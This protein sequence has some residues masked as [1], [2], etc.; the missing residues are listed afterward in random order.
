MSD[1]GFRTL[2]TETAYSGRS[3]VRL[4]RVLTPAGEEV[5]R[6]IVGHDDAVAVVPV[7]A[8]G[9]VVLLRQYRQAVRD[10]VLE[11]PAGTLDEEDASPEE[12]AS[13]ELAEETGYATEALAH[14]ITFANSAGWTDERTHVFLARDVQQRGHPE[15][16]VAEDEEADMAVVHLALAEAVGWARGGELGDAKTVIGLLLAAG[17]D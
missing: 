4:E 1:D 16:F 6:E 8:D 2:A 10:Y 3:T 13:R 12:A 5:E 14:L 17:R 9:R 15:G 7:T 11:I